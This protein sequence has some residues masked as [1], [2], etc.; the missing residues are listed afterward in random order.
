VKRAQGTSGGRFLGADITPAFRGI[1]ASTG[2]GAVQPEEVL[3]RLN[4]YWPV[5]AER[6]PGAGRTAS[7]CI[8]ASRSSC[9]QFCA[10]PP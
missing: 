7:C 5:G 10:I 9:S 1:S 6:A 3:E 8:K 2:P 4:S